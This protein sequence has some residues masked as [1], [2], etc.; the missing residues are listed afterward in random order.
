MELADNETGGINNDISNPVVKTRS[1]KAYR[2][3]ATATLLASLVVLALLWLSYFLFLW[4]FKNKVIQMFHGRQSSIVFYTRDTIV[5][6]G[7]HS[8]ILTMTLENQLK[9]GLSEDLITSLDLADSTP[10]KGDFIS[11]G[12][13]ITIYDNRIPHMSGVLEKHFRKENGF[14]I[15]D[16]TQINAMI[17][18]YASKLKFST[19]FPFLVNGISVIGDKTY[20]VTAIK[21]PL[22]KKDFTFMI[23]GDMEKILNEFGYYD[24]QEQ[25]GI[26]SILF[27]LVIIGFEFLL[28]R[29]FLIDRA[30]YNR[31]EE[32]AISL[33]QEIRERTAA[34]QGIR[35]SE[36]K[37]RSLFESSNELIYLLETDGTIVQ[38]NPEV[39]KVTG[40]SPEEMKGKKIYEFYPKEL[41]ELCEAK[42]S[43]ILLEGT[44][45]HEVEFICKDGSVLNLDCSGSLMTDDHGNPLSI[46]VFQRDITRQKLDAQ[47][48]EQLQLQ[49]LQSQKLQAIGQLSGGMAHDFNNMLAVI[50]GN[51]NLGISMLKKDDP[52]YEEFQEI[53]NAS[54]RAKELTSKL[55]TFA[56]REKINVTTVLISDIIKDL[57]TM[58][59]RSFPKK[60]ELR[61]EIHDNI[62]VNVDVTQIQQALLNV[63]NNARDAM[64]DGGVLSIVVKEIVLDSEFMRRHHDMQPGRFCHIAIS[65]TGKGMTKEMI[66][67]AFEPFYTTKSTGKGTGLGLSVTLGIFQNHG[68]DIMIESSKG[69]GSTFNL[70]LP[71]SK[72]TVE[73]KTMTKSPEGRNGSETILIIDDELSVLKLADR[74]LARAG[75][76]TI[77]TGNGVEAVEIFLKRHDEIDLV[78]LDMIM[79]V[80]DGEDVF[81]ALRRIDPGAKVILSSGYSDD[82]KAGDLLEMGV[83][84]FVQ[85]PYTIEKLCET[86]RKALDS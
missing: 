24:R 53:Y 27:S 43:I 48:K 60:I 78:V 72:R 16:D 18:K 82:G 15:S 70:F 17:N 81:K 76:K 65:D 31:T 58:L 51:A 23:Y 57:A 28:I 10:Q 69:K 32:L 52:G 37:F 86:V 29:S 12:N 35:E 42:L 55:L 73:E 39:F 13:V 22:L 66:D 54:E 8:K 21:I 44:M 56:R 1:K 30:M 4:D 64:P 67:R 77:A 26:F 41:N 2:G 38:T 34:E 7:R 40:F 3:A 45:R 75:Y 68:G 25:L 80:M 5:K 14:F 36:K 61:Q 9:N 49:L 74:I 71:A 85:K 83:I 59:D 79:P 6:A 46:V 84:G 19:D 62:P 33:H 47:E 20:L 63:C 11:Y 50:L